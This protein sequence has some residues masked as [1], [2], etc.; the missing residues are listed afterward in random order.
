MCIDYIGYFLKYRAIFGSGFFSFSFQS[1]CRIE[2]GIL[3][4]L[5]CRYMATVGVD[6]QMKIWD[7]RN[8]GQCLQNYTISS[9]ASNVAFSQKGL[10]SVAIGNVVE[11]CN[12]VLK[13]YII[14]TA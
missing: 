6:R 12:A 2:T 3:M 10:L 1:W 8:L 13:L 9:G 14:V 11:V 4:K 5:F 7:A